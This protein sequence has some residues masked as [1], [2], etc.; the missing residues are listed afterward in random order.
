ME[1]VKSPVIPWEGI[2]EAETRITGYGGLKV[3]ISDDH[4]LKSTDKASIYL[5]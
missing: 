2:D 4:S 1:E 3:N 5:K